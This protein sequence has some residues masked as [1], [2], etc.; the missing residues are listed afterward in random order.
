MYS[1]SLPP[2]THEHRPLRLTSDDQRRFPT[3]QCRYIVLHP[4]VQNQQ[5]TCQGFHHNRNAPGTSCECGHQACYH[6]H[7]Q[8]PGQDGLLGGDAFQLA[9]INNLLDRVRRLEDALQDE[10]QVRDT[11]I[12]EERRIRDREIRVL[13]EAL[14]PFYKSEEDMRRKLIELEDRLDSNIDEQTRLRERIVSIDDAGMTLEKRVDELDGF[15]KRRR[16]SRLPGDDGALSPPGSKHGSNPSSSDDKLFP[17]PPP[18][19]RLSPVRASPL[20]SPRAQSPRSSG[21]LNLAR[22][23]RSP[24]PT[25]VQRISPPQ[26]EVRSSGFLALDLAERFNQRMS[27]S[28]DRSTRHDV[29]PSIASHL[30]VVHPAPPRGGIGNIRELILS[31]PTQPQQIPP[32][33]REN[34]HYPGS[35]PIPGL[36]AYPNPKNAYTTIDIQEISAPSSI[37]SNPDSPKKR[38]RDGEQLMALDVLAN[39]SVASPLA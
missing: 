9:K 25:G 33:T 11:S 38:K 13:R 19:Y 36:P 3:G 39:V 34:Y 22:N 17:R 21:I 12:V 14:A 20:P 6:V 32:S 37:E 30:Q 7:N 27:A 15:R 5:C 10:R 18:R 4:S 1:H 31:L 26:E 29:G 23:G 2:L 8:N 16:L 35:R 24:H 28:P